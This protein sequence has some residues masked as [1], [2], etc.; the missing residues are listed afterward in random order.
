MWI[1]DTFQQTIFRLHRVRAAS[2]AA[3]VDVY[4]RQARQGLRHESACRGVIEFAENVAVG[5]TL[6]LQE[7]R[8]AAGAARDCCQRKR[9]F[10]AFV[11][12]GLVFA[13]DVT[14]EIVAQSRHKEFDGV[15]SPFVEESDLLR[16]FVNAVSYTHLDVYKR[17]R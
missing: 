5:E 4:K 1:Y 6:V 2:V 12:E 7:G 14:C 3:A 17:Q 8:P 11:E 15:G 9:V 13:S 10:L 16:L